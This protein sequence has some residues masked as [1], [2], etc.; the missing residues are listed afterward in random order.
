MRYMLII[1][2]WL[3]KYGLWVDLQGMYKKQN[4]LPKDKL[5]ASKQNLT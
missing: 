4:Q 3:Y 2:Y 1:D 5:P